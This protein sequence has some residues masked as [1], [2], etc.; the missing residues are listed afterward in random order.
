MLTFLC[1]AKAATQGKSSPGV[2]EAILVDCF[3]IH[4]PGAVGRDWGKCPLSI[5]TTFFSLSIE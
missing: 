4:S 2:P 1:C 5:K 3:E